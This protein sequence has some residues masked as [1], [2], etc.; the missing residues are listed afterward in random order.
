MLHKYLERLLFAQ[1]TGQ[2]N[3]P[4]LP[5]I[6]EQIFDDENFCIGATTDSVLLVIGPD[7]DSVDFMVTV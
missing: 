5:G 4:E 2:I 1:N 7:T 3:Q 6:G